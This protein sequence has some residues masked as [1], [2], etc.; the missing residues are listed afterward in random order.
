MSNF[1]QGSERNFVIKMTTKAMGTK[2][3]KMAQHV[4]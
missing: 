2:G 1:Q 3:W 4:P